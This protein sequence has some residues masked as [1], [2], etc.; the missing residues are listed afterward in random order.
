MHSTQTYDISLEI[1]TDG[2]CLAHVLNLS[3]R[4]TDH[5]SEPW[6]ARKALRHLLEH[7]REHT[8]HIVEVLANCD[9]T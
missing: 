3:T 7:E 1:G 9:F 5:P 4:W 8:A 6:T 2:A